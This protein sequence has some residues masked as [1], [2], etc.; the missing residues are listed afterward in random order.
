MGLDRVERVVDGLIARRPGA[1]HARRRDLARDASGP[2]GREG[3]AR[4]SSRLRPHGLAGPTLLVIGDVA[5]LELVAPRKLAIA[6]EGCLARALD[7]V[8]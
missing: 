3:D 4:N 2:G 6:Q 7:Y 1:R 5:A 8:A